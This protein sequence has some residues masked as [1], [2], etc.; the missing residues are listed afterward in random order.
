MPLNR[1]NHFIACIGIGLLSVCNGKAQSD[2]IHL[3]V[4]ALFD[5]EG[6]K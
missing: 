5:L 1:I 6:R 3:S 2:S 4:Q